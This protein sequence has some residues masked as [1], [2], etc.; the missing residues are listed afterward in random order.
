[1]DKKRLQKLD[2]NSIQNH[3][4]L[5]QGWHDDSKSS[6]NHWGIKEEVILKNIDNIKNIVQ[7][8]FKENVWCEKELEDEKKCMKII[9]E[10]LIR[11]D[12]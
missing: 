6:L 9:S 10:K 5:K 12:Y 1:M 8:K 7:D 2:S 11:K 3:Q 4:R